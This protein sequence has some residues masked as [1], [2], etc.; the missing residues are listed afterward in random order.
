MP[1]NIIKYVTLK[2]FLNNYCFKKRELLLQ[3]LEQVQS[4]LCL[5]QEKIK[6]FV[7]RDREE[8]L[9]CSWKNS[10]RETEV[11]CLHPLLSMFFLEMNKGK[12]ASGRGLKFAV[13]RNIFNK[14]NVVDARDFLFPLHFHTLFFIHP[15]LRPGRL[16]SIRCTGSWLPVGFGPWDVLARGRRVRS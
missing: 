13:R 7:N 5:I 12:Y 11:M 16:N 1:R 4:Y 6:I 9:K 3:I 10:A 15:A 2:T 14:M 8:R